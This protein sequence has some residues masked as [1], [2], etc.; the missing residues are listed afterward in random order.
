MTKSVPA[1]ATDAFCQA[2]SVAPTFPR[3]EAE[4]DEVT[5]ARARHVISEIERTTQAT[6]AMREILLGQLM[7]ESHV[8]LRDDFDVSSEAP[9]TIVDCARATDGC[10]GARMSG[11][12]VGGCAVALVDGEKAQKFCA[13][14]EATY[15]T[16]SGHEPQHSAYVCAATDGACVV[17]ED[18]GDDTLE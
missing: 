14:V 4:L 11:A 10:L 7:D 3:H 18:E 8:S 2:C 6:T 13:K 1:Q 17:V 5:R 15:R 12:G 16:R 9:D